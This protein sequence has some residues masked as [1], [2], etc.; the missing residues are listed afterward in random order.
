MSGL[1]E[2]DWESARDIGVMNSL[3]YLKV[4]DEFDNLKMHGHQINKRVEV[5]IPYIHLRKELRQLHEK[6]S[7]LHQLNY[8]HASASQRLK[9][10]IY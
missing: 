10:L 6:I 1:I 8:L 5:I 2:P 3:R 7:V 4:L 9:E